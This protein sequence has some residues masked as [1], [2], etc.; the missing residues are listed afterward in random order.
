VLMLRLHQFIDQA[1]S[2][3]ETYAPLLPAGSHTQRR[4]QMRFSNVCVPY[5]PPE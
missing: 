2:R 5:Y 4:E 1:R 3:G